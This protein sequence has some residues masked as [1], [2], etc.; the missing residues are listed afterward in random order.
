MSKALGD[1]LV[2]DATETFW[3]STGVAMLADF[4]ARVLK[5]ELLP[6]ARERRIIRAGGESRRFDGWDHE[7]ALANRNTSSLAID[8][9]V[10][11]GAA[12]VAALLSRADVFVTDRPRAQL[13]ETACGYERASEA[14]PGLIYARASGFGPEGDHSVLPALDELAAGRTG[15]MPILGQP[16]EPPVY[17]GIGQ[18]Y[19]SVMLA[20]GV[21][22]ALWHRE[23]TGEGQ[24]V[25][26]SLFG[27]NMYGASLDLQAYLAI[28][29]DRFLRPISRLDAGNP[30]SGPVYPAQDGRW[31]TL[32]MPDTDR[33]C[34]AFAA[35]TG[36]DPGDRRFD[37]HEK[38]CGEHRIEMIGVLDNVFKTRTADEWRAAF[39]EHGLSGD[40][41]ED[42]AYPAADEHARRNRY[43]LD[44]D[45][46][47]ARRVRMLGFPIFMSDTSA[48]LDR[49]AP[50]LGQHSADILHELVG[51]SEDETAELEAQGVIG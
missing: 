39:R 22:T 27:G 16:G 47:N 21:V 33:Y 37:T 29:G 15:M 31:V 12:I 38:R 4:G 46:P 5:L 45:D 28:G 48:R 32:T 9:H 44:L 41:I 42:Y 36:L 3:A 35:V 1:L 43:I 30:M 10:P 14:N 24:E 34:P 17:A 18:M 50:A 19:T 49:Q 6:E 2:I 23:E 13:E 40:V 11:E 25:D 26:V 51:R 20:L 8:A 7:F